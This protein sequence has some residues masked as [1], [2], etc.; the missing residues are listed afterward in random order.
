MPGRLTPSAVRE[1][2]ASRRIEPLYLVSGDD[3]VAMA[4]LATAI[5]DSVP[6]EVRACNVQRFDGA[7]TG[8]RLAAVLDAAGTL[9][10]LADR[11]VVLLL[12]AERVLTGRRGGTAADV[13]EEAGREG[14]PPEE[15]GG[16]KGQLARL[17]EYAKAP[18]AHATVVL[19]GGPSL[20]RSF[21]GMAPNAAVVVCG[22]GDDVIGAAAAE[23]GVRFELDA[24]EML[25]RGAGD[26]ASRLRD[27]VER[28]ILFAAGRQV[29]TREHVAAVVGRPAAAGGKTL[30]NALAARNTGAALAEL[31]MELAEGALPFMLLGLMRSVVERTVPAR[32]LPAAVDALMRTDLALKTSAG[33]PRVLL[34]RLVVELCAAGRG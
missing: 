18:Y 4:D 26:D 13:E 33:D 7:D 1:Q 9:P 16:A 11:R 12:Q 25:R 31:G 14:S 19:V 21:E 22:A 34:E 28:V 20:L 8:T 6:E 10:L 29:I 15:E 23:Y 32:D 27:E 2:V 5:A 17:K 30:W 24:A 3:E